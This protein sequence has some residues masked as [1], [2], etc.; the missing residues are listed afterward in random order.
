MRIRKAVIPAAG[1]GTRFLPMTKATAKEMINI[2]DKPAIQYVVEE[3]VASG[4]EEILIITMSGK[5]SIENHFDRS[6]ALEAV[7]K[8]QKKEELL[9]EMIEISQM[10]DVSYKRQKSINGLGAAILEAKAFVGDEP[11]AVLLADDIMAGSCPG[12]KEL[13]EVY[14]SVKGSVLALENVNKEEVSKYGI[15]EG[16]FLNEHLCEVKS[17]VEKPR[18]EEAPSQVALVG[19]YV[20]SPTIFDILEHTEAGYN[21]E[22]QLT[23]AINELAD[24]EPVHGHV[25][26]CNR[27]DVGDKLGYLKATVAFGLKH[28]TLKDD[29]LQYLKTLT[30]P[31]E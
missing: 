19:R 12:L 3:A 13:I 29:F 8:E 5:S 6:Y 25:L 31:V 11:F 4:V 30:D 10:V 15:V 21:N 1:Y 22:I 20:L 2:V 26:T 9:N 23:D 17:L 27:F 14:D 16:Y 28:E 24:K 7:L 18:V